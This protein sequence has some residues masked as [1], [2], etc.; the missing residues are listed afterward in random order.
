MGVFNSVLT[1]IGATNPAHSSPLIYPLPTT[2]NFPIPEHL[3]LFSLYVLTHLTN[4]WPPT[5]TGLH[6]TS[7]CTGVVLIFTD[8]IFMDVYNGVLNSN[9]S[10]R[11]QDWALSPKFGIR[12]E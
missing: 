12:L 5:S 10:A 8:V 2:P 9:Q 11:V 7:S 1:S 6:W 4:A 3:F